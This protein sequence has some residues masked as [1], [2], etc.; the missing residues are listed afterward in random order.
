MLKKQ[1]FNPMVLFLA[2]AVA[3]LPAFSTG[4]GQVRFG[5]PINLSD[6]PS[7]SWNPWIAAVDDQVFVVWRDEL[8]PRF[9]GD[10]LLAH[11]RDKGM[12]FRYG[13]L[14]GD[15]EI[16][17]GVLPSVVAD[18]NNIYVGWSGLGGGGIRSWAP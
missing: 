7:D 6:N 15:L 10:I 17:N 13:N 14:T 16:H 5:S 12:T 18:Q 1:A 9:L 2:S 11:S 8:R 3:L 4:M